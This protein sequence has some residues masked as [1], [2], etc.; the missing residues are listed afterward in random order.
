MKNLILVLLLILFLVTGCSRATSIGKIYLDDG[1]NV[2]YVKG[3][4]TSPFSGE[5]VSVLDRFRYDPKTDKSEL[6]KSDSAS[7]NNKFKDTIKSLPIPLPI[8]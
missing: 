7:S 3:R 2:L 1:S 6:I 5:T 4:V 8:P